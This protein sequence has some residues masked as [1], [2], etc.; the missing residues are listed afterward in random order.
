MSSRRRF[1][2]FCARVFHSRDRNSRSLDES[3][4]PRARWEGWGIVSIDASRTTR[5]TRTMAHDVDR[6]LCPIVDRET[7]APIVASLAR[8]LRSRVEARTTAPRDRGGSFSCYEGGARTTDGGRVRRTRERER[9]AGEFGGRESKCARWMDHRGMRAGGGRRAGRG[10]RRAR[11]RVLAEDGG[12]RDERRAR[13]C[14]RSR[15][16]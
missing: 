7:R 6:R 14:G 11:A 16:P 9:D 10:R 8:T 13:G 4:R 3:P 5:T 1:G 15:W 2:D 12:T